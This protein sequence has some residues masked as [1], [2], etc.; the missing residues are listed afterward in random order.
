MKIVVL[1]G[2][3]S[4]ERDVSLSSGAGICRTLRER[5]HRAILLD[6]FLGLPDVPENLEDRTETRPKRGGKTQYRPGFLRDGRFPSGCFFGKMR[7]EVL[8]G[9]SIRRPGGAE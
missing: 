2:G 6:V 5:G 8:A 7:S 4:T 1:A 9:R 3:L